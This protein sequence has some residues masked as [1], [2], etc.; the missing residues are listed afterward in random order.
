[1]LTAALSQAARAFTVEDDHEGSKLWTW[2]SG[3]RQHL[4]LCPSASHFQGVNILGN[5]FLSYYPAE[6]RDLSD[7]NNRF[8]FL[9]GAKIEGSHKPDNIYHWEDTTAGYKL[10]MNSY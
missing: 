10:S 2:I 4:H 9:V 7:G 3:H 6:V 8:A 5:D 1:L